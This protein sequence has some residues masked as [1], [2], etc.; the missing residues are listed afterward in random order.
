MSQWGDS[1]S[2]V[3][4]RRVSRLRRYT[5]PASSRAC[6]VSST[7]PDRQCS[8]AVSAA[9]AR[10]LAAGLLLA[11]AAL[12]AGPAQALH[13][14]H[15]PSQS[16]P[17]PNHSHW[18]TRVTVGHFSAYAGHRWLGW[19]AV[20]AGANEAEDYLDSVNA[21]LPGIGDRTIDWNGV[22]YL[23]VWSV[24]FGETPRGAGYRRGASV[25]LESITPEWSE[26][27]SRTSGYLPQGTVFN[28]GGTCFMA[29]AVYETNNGKDGYRWWH[30]D[31]EWKKG[32]VVTFSVTFSRAPPPPDIPNNVPR[33]FLH[34]DDGNGN[35]QIVTFTDTRGRTQRIRLESDDRW[36]DETVGDATEASV[37]NVGAPVTA[38]DPEPDGTVTGYRLDGPDA[39]KFT[40]N[41]SNGQIRTKPGEHYDREAAQWKFEVEVQATDREGAV[42]TAPVFL[43]AENLKEPPLVPAAPSAWSPGASSLYVTWTAPSN[44]GRP[45]IDGHDLRYRASGLGG[46]ALVQGTGLYEPLWPWRRGPSNVTGT[47]AIFTVP[48]IYNDIITKV[49]DGGAYEVQVRARNADGPGAWSPSGIAPELVVDDT[50]GG[51]ETP[52]T[53]TLQSVPLEHDGSSLFTFRIS[54]GDAVTITAENL[55]NHALVVGGGTVTS[56]SAVA[57]RN[58]LFEVTVTPSG[59]GA[60]SI[61][62][63]QGSACT[64]LGAICTSDG[65]RL[66]T[67]LE[68]SVPGPA[69]PPP[70]VWPLTA[71][72]Q[73]VPLAH[74]GSSA[75]TF[76][77]AFSED[78]TITPAN[79][80]AHALEVSG[81]TVTDVSAVGGRSDLFEV[82]ITPSGDGAVEIQTPQGRACAESGAICTSDNR[83]LSIA[84]ARSVAGP[85]RQRT[86]TA[87]F[88]SAPAEHDGSRAFTF[89]IAFS[90]DVTIT[91]ENLRDH[92]L[93]VS[94]GTVKGAS[95]VDGRRDLFEVTIKPS[96]SRAVS[97][98]VQKGRDCT[99]PGAICTSD[100]RTL[101][102]ALERS[103]AGPTQRGPRRPSPLT[104]SFQSVPAEHDGA[105][106]FTFRIAFSDNVTITPADLGGHALE[107]SGGTVTS[108]SAVD[109]RSDL[110][111]VTITPSGDEAVEIHV[112]QGRACTESGAICTSD[113]R[114][115]GITLERSVAGPPPPPSPLTASFQSAPAAHDGA[116]VF[117]FRI[118][119]SEAVTI[120]AENLRDHALAVTRGTVTGVSALSGSGFE[121]TVTP[122]GNGAVRIRVQAGISC[123]EPGAICTSDD[124][125]LSTGLTLA[126]AGPVQEG[127]PLTAS[128]RS[129]PRKHDGSSA[130]TFR[131]AFN[132]DV[133]ITAA[134]LGAYALAVSGGTVLMAAQKR[135]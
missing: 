42:G 103:V 132:H 35:R 39:D 89:R 121:V 125:T 48:G 129:V 73:S 14:L 20:L 21:I 5:G 115:L 98:Q 36:F 133:T 99:E 94:G 87:I 34:E 105:N 28:L 19:S 69:P 80:G 64:E 17:C 106:A 110:F 41:P 130:F 54:F 12:A 38:T 9:P 15:P 57:G 92:A 7:L 107:V 50:I 30:P 128:F 127:P 43:M 37:R 47:G 67:S 52:L 3:L 63:R 26:H 40:I 70:P 131:I 114:A 100:A 61:L 11:V 126:I 134:N 4:A 77:I 25:Y 97:I 49:H 117:T 6:V 8:G 56:V 111:E 112:P 78:V 45:V 122:S 44:P 46:T 31:L 76:R 75:F 91:P 62:V 10:T 71:A 119:F 83:R 33:F 24:G 16:V 102:V 104:A 84:L 2:G 23:Y 55:R 93:E 113:N 59:H 116:S 18:S 65:R 85:P 66:S 60:V 123:T 74:D 1:V 68:E 118:L 101:S 108:V 109:G 22:P 135:L 27:R 120:S 88:Q 82:T 124:R 72:L 29:D 32:E 96:G 90:E 95:A 51:T 53:A 81:G 58:D 79:L 13:A 86:L